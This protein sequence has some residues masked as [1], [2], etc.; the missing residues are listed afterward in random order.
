M[1][2][3]ETLSSPTKLARLGHFLPGSQAGRLAGPVFYVYVFSLVLPLLR[4]VRW[5]EEYSSWSK[6][7]R[8]D[9]PHVTEITQKFG[10][11]LWLFCQ[12]E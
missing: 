12:Y 3:W 11:L 10:I 7:Q 5:G 8:L 6:P 9:L 4:D 1:R 2:A